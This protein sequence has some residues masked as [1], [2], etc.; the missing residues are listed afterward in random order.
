[1][2]IKHRTE[3]AIEGESV[4]DLIEELSKFIGK[5]AIVG[6]VGSYGCSSIDIVV[7]R[8]ETP[9]EIVAKA[10]RLKRNI[11]REQ[12]DKEILD[13]HFNRGNLRSGLCESDR[14][15]ISRGDAV[16]MYL[17]GFSKKKPYQLG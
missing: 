3:L 4:E 13:A 9:E 17:E 12:K 1:M 8:E 7:E 2:K 16:P 6:D 5:G 11:E 10:E 15:I 14:Q